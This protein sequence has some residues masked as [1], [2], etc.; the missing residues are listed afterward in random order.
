MYVREDDWELTKVLRKR[1]DYL[2][3]EQS[4]NVSLAPLPPTCIQLIIQSSNELLSSL[5][6]YL[7]TF[8]HDLSDVSGQISELQQRS[9]EI[10]AQLKGRKVPSPLHPISVSSSDW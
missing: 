7:S 10:E 1:K 8:Q 2:E 3:L 6:S 4:V 9:T 5:A